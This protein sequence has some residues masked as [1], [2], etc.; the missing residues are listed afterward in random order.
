MTFYHFR[1][2]TAWKMN[3]IFFR[4]HTYRC[5]PEGMI[6]IKQIAIR[7]S[8]QLGGKKIQNMCFWH[9]IFAMW[10]SIVWHTKVHQILFESSFIELILLSNAINKLAILDYH[11]WLYYR[12]KIE[13]STRSA[14][15][16]C[17]NYYE[18]F[19]IAL[20]NRTKIKQ[21]FWF[22]LLVFDDNKFL[23]NLA[24]DPSIHLK[25]A[26]RVCIEYF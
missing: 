13:A 12:D 22:L 24:W 17:T 4:P 21:Y 14:L 1:K 11:S 25:P 16:L 3:A 20:S 10:S 23:L 19:S 2:Y 5:S 7:I 26:P 6:S 9:S 15:S 8:L 18:P